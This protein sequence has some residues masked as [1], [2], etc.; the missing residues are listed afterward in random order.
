[1]KLTILLLFISYIYGCG[2]K[3]EKPQQADRIRQMDSILATPT[4]SMKDTGLLAPIDS[5]LKIVFQ[6][7]KL[8]DSLGIRNIRFP[9]GGLL[10]DNY[11]EPTSKRGFEVYFWDHGHR[12]Q[13]FGGKF[14]KARFSNENI[15]DSITIE[16]SKP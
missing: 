3:T 2:G 10:K 16:M 6:H 8:F 1:M 12:F 9:S 7:W 14:K 5:G 13:F 4:R 11:F 15:I